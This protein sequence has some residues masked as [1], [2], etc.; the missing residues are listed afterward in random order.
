MPGWRFFGQTKKP[1]TPDK[2]INLGVDDDYIYIN[3]GPAIDS[4][5]RKETSDTALKATL[6]LVGNLLGITGDISRVKDA[7]INLDSAKLKIRQLNKISVKDYIQK[8]ESKNKK[9]IVKNS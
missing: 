8:L 7:S 5:Y 9:E 1:D 2:L 3:E 6:P 4:A